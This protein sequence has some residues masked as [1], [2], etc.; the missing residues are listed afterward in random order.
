MQKRRIIS[1]P[2][3]LLIVISSGWKTSS[4]HRHLPFP[5]L[6]CSP[7]L[8]RMSYH[9][10][11]PLQMY[12]RRI[13]LSWT[14]VPIS[15][16]MWLW[17]KSWVFKPWSEILR[18]RSRTALKW[19]RIWVT[20]TTIHFKLQRKLSHQFPA[21]SSA[22]LKL[23]N[24]VRTDFVPKASRHCAAKKVS[25]VWNEIFMNFRVTI[26]QL[27]SKSKLFGRWSREKERRKSASQSLKKDWWW[28]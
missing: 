26:G 5:G 20:R 2:S 21:I 25:A 19:R 17:W 13:R 6:E 12:W 8:L 11:R 28:F 23:G 9:A 27:K 16:R 10:K 1:Y 14:E 7:W 15:V 3:S 4:W 22:M 18:K 24:R